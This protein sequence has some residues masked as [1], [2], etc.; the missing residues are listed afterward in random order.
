VSGRPRGA[1]DPR[2]TLDESRLLLHTLGDGATA[3]A[4]RLGVTRQAVDRAL[5]EGLSV[6]MARRWGLIP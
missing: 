3:I 1:R 6:R 5:R 2:L 4:E